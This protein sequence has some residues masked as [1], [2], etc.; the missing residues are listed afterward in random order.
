M[1]RPLFGV[2]GRIYPKLDWAPRV[3][4][5][6]T[7]FQELAVDSVE[8]YF[9]SVSI[10]PNDLRRRLF[11]PAMRSDLQG[12]RAVEVLR[13]H[14]ENAPVDHHLD[15]VQYADIKTYLPG[16]IL[17]KVDRASM[18]HSLEVRVPMLDHLLVEWA[19]C[20]PARLRLRGRE[21]KYV[22]K[23]AMAPYLAQDVLYREKMG[24]AVPLVD[25]FRGP[26]RETTRNALSGGALAEAGLFD[27]GFVAK[28][29]DQHQS[30]MRDH[31]AALWALL[32]FDSFL[33]NVD[34][35]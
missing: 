5:A 12:Y 11:S 18:A 3:L 25:W 30:G 27:M 31:S 29:V 10:M 19:A 24:F 23:S 9:N 6:K 17:T 26:L 4:R 14:M 1:R 33:R 20:L 34:A 32:M 21:G 13:G 2:L 16:D 15:R 35:V 7:T 22:L 8:S 28:L